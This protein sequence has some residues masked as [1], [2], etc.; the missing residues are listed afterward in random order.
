MRVLL[1]DFQ[2]EIQLE[3]TNSF[4]L[5]N[6]VLAIILIFLV[7]HTPSEMIKRGIKLLY[8]ELITLLSIFKGTVHMN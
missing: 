8:A 5:K 7:F 2:L 6:L 1:L 3:H 4:N